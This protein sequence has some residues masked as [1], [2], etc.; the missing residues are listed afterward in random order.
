M[1]QCTA[2]LLAVVLGVVRSNA[3][4][5]QPLE[6]LVWGPGPHEARS[7]SEIKLYGTNGGSWLRDFLKDSVLLIPNISVRL[8]ICL[9][10][11]GIRYVYGVTSQTLLVKPM[12]YLK[13]GE[14]LINM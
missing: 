13:N 9:I 4:E 3:Q 7:S 2:L 6:G 12:M 1:Q 10:L 14:S 8:L 5:A 11:L